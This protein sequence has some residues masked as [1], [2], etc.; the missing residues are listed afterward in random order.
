MLTKRFGTIVIEDLAVKNMVRNRSLSRA[1]SDA[2]FGTLRRMIEYKA[3]LAR[4]SGDRRRPV[5]SVF[6][7]L[8]GLRRHQGRVVAGR[9]RLPV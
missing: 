3:G 4:R 2:G 7:N 5:L 6:E 1:I 9:T 8:R